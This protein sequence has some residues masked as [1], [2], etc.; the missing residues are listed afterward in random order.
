MYCVKCIG[1]DVDFQRNLAT[2]PIGWEHPKVIARREGIKNGTVKGKSS[3][4]KAPPVEDLDHPDTS[5]KVAKS[6]S[7]RNAKKRKEIEVN[8]RGEDDSAMVISDNDNDS[9][10]TKGTN[11]KPK[12]A[13]VP[14]GTRSRP[15]RL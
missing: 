13:Y 7:K 4:R 15:I 14:K 2:M 11:K 1:Y 10:E 6:P 8:D 3:K 9:S 12:K 5:T